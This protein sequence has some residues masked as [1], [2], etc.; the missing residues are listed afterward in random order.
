MLRS[1]FRFP[2]RLGIPVIY[3]LTGALWILFSDQLAALIST[4]DEMHLRISMA[5]G[6]AFVLVNGIMLYFLIERNNRSLVEASQNYKLLAE[7]TSDVIW[8]MD[9]VA[10]RFTYVSPSVEKLRGYTA[11]EVMARPVR[12][13]LTPESWKTVNN[14]VTEKLPAFLAKGT[15]SMSSIKEVD[16]P[17]K[18]G[19]IV[20]TEVTTTYMFTPQGKVEIVGVTRDITE[21]KRSERI[22]RQWAD[23]FEHCAHGI[24][25]GDAKTNRIRTCNP[26]FAREQGGEIAEFLNTPLLEMYLPKDHEQIKQYLAESDH[27]GSVRFEADKIRK[28]GSTYPVQMD[29]VSVK[30]ENGN[31]LYRVA[32]QQDITERRKAEKEVREAH[33]LFQ[34]IFNLS[35]FAIALARASDRVILDVNPAAE[36]M[37]GYARAEL[38]GRPSTNFDYWLDGEERQRG[39]ETTLREGSLRNFEFR[40]KDK[41]GWTGVAVTSTEAFE[42]N[43]E[44]YFLSTFIDVTAR[45]KV[46]EELRA[47]EERF[48]RTLDDMLEGCQIIDFN[49]RY[50]YVNKAVSAQGR[51]TRE[52]LLGR[53]MMEMYPGIETTE[54]FTF[55]RTCMEQRT[56]RH[57]DN[58]FF[59]PD[60]S[61]GWYELSIQP[62][63]EGLFIL[64]IDITERK[65]VEEELRASE[66][67]Y[68]LLFESNPH[69]MWVY[70]ADTLKFLVV[71]DAAIHHYGYT[72]DE[73]LAMTIKDIRPSEEIPGLLENLARESAVLQRSGT[74][75]H[76]L[77][78]G[79]LIDVEIHS[80]ALQ[81]NNVSARL[82]LA[83]DVTERK[84]AEDALRKSEALLA[85]AQR[86]G[87][88]GHI[89]WTISDKDLVCSDEIYRIFEI[90]AGQPLSQRTISSLM[91]PEEEAR[92]RELDKQAFASRSNLD[93]EYRVNLPSGMQR[94]LHQF[95]EVT[96]DENGRPIRLMGILQD[97][98]ERKI[99]EQ[100][101]RES[102]GRFSKVF[103]DSPIGINI[104]RLVDGISVNINDA[105]LEI[106][107][108]TCEE[109]LGHSAAELNLFVDLEARNT[110]MKRMINGEVLRNQDAKIRRKS[111]E[112]RDTLASLDLIDINGEPM[113]LVIAT[114][115]TERKLAE[116]KVQTQIERI[117]A[118]SRIDR[119]ISASLDMRMSLDVLLSELLS[120]LAVDAADI[121]LLN[122]AGQTLEYAAGKGFRSTAVRR[123]RISLGESLAGEAGRERKVIH[124]PDLEAAG[125]KYVRKDTFKEEE[126]KEYYGIPLIAK[127]KLKGVLEVFHRAYLEP[128]PDWL[129]YMETLGGQ[130]AIAIDNAQ[131]FERLQQSN[132]ELITAYDATI[133]GWSLAMDLRDKETEGHTQRVTDLT[134][135]LSEKLGI[136]Q[137]EIGHIRRGALLHDIGKLGVPDHILLKPGKL[138]EDEWGIMHQ[139]PIYAL[140]MLLPIAYLRPAL[141]IPYCHHEKWDGTGYPRGLK[142]EQIPFAARLFAIVDVWDAL[143]ANRPYREKWS[144]EQTRAYILEQ[145]GKHFEPR[146]VTAFLA[147]LDERPDL[148]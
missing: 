19:S 130:A 92:L 116:V 56:S 36:K 98:T 88:I 34:N 43:G 30:D 4:S 106:I 128:D 77:K 17:C 9:P 67:K 117:T 134:V 124:I 66:E 29:L 69:P 109:V 113:V 148:L 142:G 123:S 5:K 86:I 26:A 68:K 141:D 22:V 139:H 49:W 112:I 94:W 33:Q 24:V 72:R 23:A 37:F 145:S 45:K 118:L 13:S 127:G 65:R 120:Q 87:R 96:Y 18:D 46:E 146:I 144:V 35:P 100:A 32:T 6:W 70:E 58:Q 53:T 64:S 42:Q 51:S 57:F 11:E 52:D 71:N 103:S 1:R 126:F 135:R 93:Y 89:E 14:G 44:A 7:N 55:L 84:L 133:L 78:N 10:G 138:T 140:N 107:G 143:R 91:S 73:F 48:H 75:K 99:A 47:S 16:Q 122:E 129:N 102:E 80:H 82:V 20:H 119:A 111:G 132:Q 40:F 90:P 3:I 76:R 21:R 136:N 38:V 12:E 54:L 28:D 137:Q 131:L 125:K 147:L 2:N 8:M 59:F 95:A 15:G 74:W 63:P 121:L 60:G 101:L 83:S 79:G 105:F 104:F 50:V 115:I 27:T 114:D 39:Y 31:L 41:S 25:I 108:Y 81:F 110:W 61:V 85:D 62:V 97:I